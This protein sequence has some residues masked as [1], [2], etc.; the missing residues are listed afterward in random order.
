MDLTGTIVGQYDILEQIGRGGMA[1]VYKAYQP[2]LDR[3]VAVK[4]LTPG[5]AQDEDFVARFER[6]ARAVARLRHRNI[7]TVFDYGRQGGVFYLVMEYAS[8]GALRERLGWPQDLA[9]AVSIVSQVG[10]ALAQAHNQGVIHRDVKPGN[11]LMA[12]DDWPLLSD[13]GLAK[14]LEDSVQLTASGVGVG[15]P[16]YMSPEQARG[17]PVDGRSDIYSLGIVLYEAV[18]GRPPFGTDAPVVVI[19]R[20]IN[21][22]LTPPRS[23]RSDLPRE[24]EHV[25][26]KALAKSPAERYQRMEEFVED[27]QAAYPPPPPHK[28]AQRGN[29]PAELAGRRAARG[30]ARTVP[31]T[32]KP[33]TPTPHP[34]RRRASPWMGGAVGAA[35]VLASVLVFLGFGASITPAASLF[36]PTATAT[37]ES[38]PAVT[39]LPTGTAT[40]E[41]SPAAAVPSPTV[42][43]PSPTAGPTISMPQSRVWE[44]DGAEMVFVPAGEFIMGSEELGDDERPA[45][46][47]YL[48]GFWIDRYEVTNEQFSRFVAATGYQT[49]AEQRGW[50]WVWQG[51]DWQKVE[52]ADWRHSH[53]P[54]DSL[55]GKVDRPVVLV[56]WK[57]ALVYCQWAGKQLPTEAQWEKAV[58]GPVT[59]PGGGRRY[60]WGDEFESGKT[61]TEES[62]RGDTVPVGSFSPQGDSPYGAADMT[63]NVWEWVADWYGSDYYAQSPPANPPGPANGTYKILRGGAWPFSEVYARAAFR[64]SVKP[65]YTYDFAGFRCVSPQ[66]H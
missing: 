66:E 55:E 34:P 32:P 21:D 33:A 61:N 42:S 17:L 15:T 31:R 30:L 41:P 47:V 46:R 23:L 56:S 10:D 62:Q 38:S 49:E 53:G 51:L 9:Y 54:A 7:L 50:G 2:T 22:P 48:D 20:H 39:A 65:D 8:G 58:R 6:E 59:G 26:L 60:A 5:L 63:G 13:F 37:V 27:L 18:T 44:A 25:I 3:Y 16:Q 64:Y 1:T 14:I 36:P 19:L 29:V 43:P 11:I 52:G 4:V 35:L 24:L 45:H 28:L 57:D 40:A 12:A